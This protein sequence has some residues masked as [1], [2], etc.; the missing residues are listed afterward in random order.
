LGYSEEERQKRFNEIVKVY[1]QRFEENK[2]KATKLMEG[3]KQV[4]KKE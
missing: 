3:S 2:S 4:K 1:D